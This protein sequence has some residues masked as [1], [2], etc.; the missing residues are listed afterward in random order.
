MSWGE[1]A[2]D[3]D[4]N[5]WSRDRMRANVERSHEIRAIG[6]ENSVISTRI[7]CQFV[8]TSDSYFA[9]D[10][11]RGLRAIRRAALWPEIAA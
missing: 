8:D 4:P 10:N 1:R 11:I 6:A 3:M 9:E 7:L 2:G 5:C